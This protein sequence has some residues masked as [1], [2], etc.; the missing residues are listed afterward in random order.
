MFKREAYICLPFFILKSQS[1]RYQTTT[2]Y[3]S[4]SIYFAFNFVRYQ[5]VIFLHN[6]A[7]HL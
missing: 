2:N 7:K 6:N 3:S 1:F 4:I 5:S